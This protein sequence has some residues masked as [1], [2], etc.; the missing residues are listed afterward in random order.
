M[1]ADPYATVQTDE[2]ETQPPGSGTA[3]ITAPVGVGDPAA[4][5]PG[6][7]E[8]PGAPMPGGAPDPVVAQPAVAGAA[9]PDKISIILA[10]LGLVV[11]IGMVVLLALM[12]V[13]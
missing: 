6:G 2:V 1:A 7:P 13:E 11:G 4:P 8:M 10:V 12:K 3:V 5:A 9:E